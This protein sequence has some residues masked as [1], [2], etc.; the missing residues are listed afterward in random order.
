MS[1]HT[2][3]T[4][5][6]RGAYVTGSNLRRETIEQHYLGA[7]APD[8]G[9]EFDRWLTAHVAQA[10]RAAQLAQ[11]AEAAAGVEAHD[12]Q[13]DEEFCGRCYAGVQSSEHHEK[14][15]AL[16]WAED[17]EPAPAD[18]LTWTAHPGPRPAPPAQ[19]GSDR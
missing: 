10:V 2:P 9:A 16:G 8:Y 5:Q 18:A 13:D 19:A 3:T 7:T 6:V 4:A 12:D 14:C 11:G 15:V 17:D 1:E